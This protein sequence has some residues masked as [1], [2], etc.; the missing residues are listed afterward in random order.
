MIEAEHPSLEEI[1]G[2]TV[3]DVL[4]AVSGGGARTVDTSRCSIEGTGDHQLVV[5]TRIEWVN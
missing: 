2:I 1:I 3:V 5:I 4:V